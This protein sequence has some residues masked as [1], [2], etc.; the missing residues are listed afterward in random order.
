MK[1]SLDYI[2]YA[3]SGIFVATYHNEPT[4]FDGLVGNMT[5]IFVQI[6]VPKEYED[7]KQIAVT[8]VDEEVPKSLIKILLK[9][10]F[11]L[12]FILP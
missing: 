1:Y 9:D 8:W 12:H 2:T 11:N 5:T 6:N 10:H 3:Y 7:D 4:A